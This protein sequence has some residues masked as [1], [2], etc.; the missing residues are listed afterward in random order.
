MKKSLGIIAG[1]VIIA[2]FL[3]ASQCFAKLGG[4]GLF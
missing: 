2:S 3:S 4:Q 1:I